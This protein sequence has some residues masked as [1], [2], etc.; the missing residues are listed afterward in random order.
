MSDLQ[1]RRRPRWSETDWKKCDGMIWAALVF[2]PLFW[3]AYAWEKFTGL[4]LAKNQLG[5]ISTPVHL[6]ATQQSAVYATFAG[7]SLALLYVVV[8]LLKRRT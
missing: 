6:A 1:G 7:V 3:L 4:T 8:R 5:Q 2:V